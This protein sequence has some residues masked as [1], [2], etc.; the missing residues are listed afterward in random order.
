MAALRRAWRDPRGRTG[1]LILAAVAAGAALGPL[2]LPDPLAGIDTTGAEQYS[3]IMDLVDD[4]N[5]ANN[6]AARK[7][8]GREIS[9]DSAAKFMTTY[10]LMEPARAQQRVRF[11]DQ[12]RSYVIN[13]NY[14]K[15]LVK[16]YVEARAAGDATRRWEIF[17]QLLASPT[18]PSALT[19][20]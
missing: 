12:Y 4:L 20:Q 15:D 1:A 11:M 3:R 5:Y 13:Y 19:G 7:Y 14:G 9:A 10:A 17:T 18:L 2:L 6:E 16:D 8:L